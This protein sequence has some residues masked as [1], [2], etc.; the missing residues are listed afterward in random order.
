[1]QGTFHAYYTVALAPGI[2]ALVAVGAR[3][4][5]R[6][7]DTWTGRGV[8]ALATAVTAGWAWVLLGRSATFLPWLRWVVLAVGIVAAVGLV[9]PKG[10]GGRLV[11]AVAGAAVLAGLAGPAAYAVDTTAT[12]HQGGIVTAGPSTGGGFGPGAGRGRADGQGGRDR[13][14]QDRTAQN[15]AGTAPGRP[16]G[17]FGGGPGGEQTGTALA[18]LLKSANT[19]WAAATIGSQGAASMELSTNTAVM[20]IGGF[21]GSD[22][23]PTLPQF[24]QYVAASEI[25][26]F[27]EGGMGGGPGRRDSEI[28]T[29]VQQ[30][31]TA[32]TVDGRTVYDLTAP[33]S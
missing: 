24:Q 7:R 3:E 1:M 14:G 29:W 27:V 8:L 31:Y 25:H 17:G 32:Q 28:T 12:A 30:H 20:A 13:T 26:Y 19:R 2:A 6:V 9:L 11:A 21:V 23:Y 10:L 4:A 18:D 5:W 22:P 16:Q 15:G 33:T